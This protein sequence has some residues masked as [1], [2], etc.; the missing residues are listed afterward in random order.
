MV[1]MVTTFMVDM[2]SCYLYHPMTIVS[3]RHFVTI[4]IPFPF[5]KAMCPK[6][7]VIILEAGQ[8]LDHTHT[9]LT[10][11][12][13]HRAKHPRPQ[14]HVWFSLYLVFKIK[15]DLEAQACDSS[16]LERLT[17]EDFK[18]ENCM[19]YRASSRLAY[20]TY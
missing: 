15:L 17:Q 1:V 5:S 10:R 20:K 13:S 6:L 11:D 12:Q 4:S 14:T 7:G 2:I 16:H 3:Y 18:F 19:G 9:V 8:L